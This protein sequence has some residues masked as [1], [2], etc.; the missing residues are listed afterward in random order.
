MGLMIKI[1]II[2]ILILI[3]LT[4]F[5]YPKKIVSYSPQA[6]IT[7]ECFG[8]MGEDRCEILSEIPEI[9]HCEK[10]CYGIS[11]SCEFKVEE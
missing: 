5:F 4:A 2:L 8:F 6:E 1:M 10:Y 7:C 3:C 9:V 11:Y